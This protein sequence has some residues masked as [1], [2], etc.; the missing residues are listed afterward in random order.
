MLRDFPLTLNHTLDG[1]KFCKGC[2]KTATIPPTMYDAPPPPSPN[3][4]AAP[5]SGALPLI[6]RTLRGGSWDL[7]LSFDPEADTITL[8]PNFLLDET[9]QPISDALRFTQFADPGVSKRAY[10]CASLPDLL[11]SV[12][13]QQKTEKHLKADQ[14]Y[15]RWSHFQL[16]RAAELHAVVMDG[17]NIVASIQTKKRG[18]ELYQYLKD[19][20]KVL[21]RK[22]LT[23]DQRLNMIRALIKA[24]YEFHT[25]SHL[26]HLDL[27]PENIIYDETTNTMHLID[28]DYSDIA[29]VPSGFK[30]TPFF[31]A[32]E[33]VGRSPHNTSQKSDVFSVGRVI[34]EILHFQDP[35]IRTFRTLDPRI[36]EPWDGIDYK[37]FE[38]QVRR[39]DLLSSWK[40]PTRTTLKNTLKSMLALDPDKRPSIA[41][42]YEA[43][44]AEPP[45]AYPPAPLMAISAEWGATTFLNHLKQQIN[46]LFV[47]KRDP[48][49]ELISRLE[50]WPATH[51]EALTDPQ[52]IRILQEADDKEAPHPGHKKD[53]EREF[54]LYAILTTAEAI[55]NSQNAEKKTVLLTKFEDLCTQTPQHQGFL[56]FQGKSVQNHLDLLRSRLQSGPKQVAL[57][58]I[59]DLKIA[60]TVLAGRPKYQS[61]TLRTKTYCQQKWTDLKRWWRDSSTTEKMVR[62]TLL[63]VGV[64]ATV[65]TGGAAAGLAVLPLMPVKSIARNTW[66]ALKGLKQRWNTAST[67]G[68]AG[69]ATGGL[70]LGAVTAGVVMLD[71]HFGGVLSHIANIASNALLHSN[72]AGAVTANAMSNSFAAPAATALH[73]TVA[74]SASLL[75]TGAVVEVSVIGA[76]SAFGKKAISKLKHCFKRES[77]A[78]VVHDNPFARAGVKSVAT[79][80]KP[81]DLRAARVAHLASPPSPHTTEARRSAHRADT[82]AAYNTAGVFAAGGP[83][84]AKGPIPPASVCA[85]GL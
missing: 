11:L 51:P 76:L 56:T 7:P 8:P 78:P 57:D 27:K 52:F 73:S 44:V 85:S 43:L 20:S 62:G 3:P 12:P 82:A 41:Q 15:L 16:Y 48:N 79:D 6:V 39:L 19:P 64:T 40:E 34:Q 84:E 2:S 35:P 81:D 60:Q 80:V 37:A 66:S 36:E 1:E 70:L 33:A 69:M 50:A 83:A 71:L 75:A 65:L 21:P 17:N 26:K 25:K 63:A 46:P 22:P 9:G 38:K 18:E 42:V 30:G 29:A 32:P 47:P 53:L 61:R 49:A 67:L 31:A 72:A 10:A 59:E 68:R 54:D 23:I 58:A 45:P 14:G 77:L 28:L 55:V 5:V 13:Y 4:D 24:V 74:V